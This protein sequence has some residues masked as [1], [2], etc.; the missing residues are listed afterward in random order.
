M[1]FTPISHNTHHHAN[2]E[3][4]HNDGG[5]DTDDDVE[6][7]TNFIDTYESSFIPDDEDGSNVFENMKLTIVLITIL[8]H[9]IEHH[10]MMV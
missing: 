6:Q 2:T 1:T 8:H 10:R 5:V 9:I 4:Q 3:L 7:Y